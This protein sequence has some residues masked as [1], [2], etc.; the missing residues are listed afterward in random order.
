M[1]PRPANQP[2]SLYVHIP[3]CASRCGYCTFTSTVYAPETADAYLAALEKELRAR[4]VFRV[5]AG[6][7]PETV[8]IGGGTPSILSLEQMERLFSFLPKSTGEFT[9]E[10]NPDSCSREKLEF[11]RDHGVNRLSFGVQTF[12]PAG[13]KLLQR[14]HSWEQAVDALRMA[15]AVGFPS[16]SIDLINGWPGQTERCV[17]ED[18]ARAVDSG[19]HHLSSYNLILEPS[20][21]G[22]ARYCELLCGETA[23]EAVGRRNW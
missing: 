12:D 10:I 23:D 15:A 19:I 8:F 5:E 9:C 22:Y 17:R 1:T 11:L 6:V 7:L 2:R 4:D 3:F 21:A 18:I 16:I 20:A 13:L 14:R